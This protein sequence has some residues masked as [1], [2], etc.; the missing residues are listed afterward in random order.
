MWPLRPSGL[1]RN[2]PPE[3]GR[4]RLEDARGRCVGRDGRRCRLGSWGPRAIGKAW[5]RTQNHERMSGGGALQPAAP[6]SSLGGRPVRGTF[7]VPVATCLER[8]SGG[9]ALEP[10]APRP[11]LV[12]RSFRCASGALC[13]IPVVLGCRGSGWRP[14]PRR[15]IHF[16]RSPA[17]TRTHGRGLRAHS[18]GLCATRARLVRLRQ[19]ARLGFADVCGFWPLRPAAPL[20]VCSAMSFLSS[21]ANVRRRS[22]EVCWPRRQALAPGAAGPKGNRKGVA[23]NRKP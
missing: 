19:F 1:Q 9:G 8:M 15:C 5:P 22:G 13:F 7:K 18:C 16:S 4:K 6:R 2:D 3:F 12:G 21:G 20:Q 10:A 23:T 14:V 11:S 17:E